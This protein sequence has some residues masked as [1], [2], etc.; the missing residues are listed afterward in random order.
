VS[1]SVA[2]LEL[3][4]EEASA[5]VALRNLIPRILG[6]QVAFHIHAYQGKPDLLNKLPNR[7]KGYRGW[8]PDDWRIVVLIDEDREDCTQIKRKL[9]DIATQAGFMTKS[10]AGVGKPFQVLNRLCVEELEAWFFGDVKAITSA[11]PRVPTSLAQRARFRN[12]DAIVGGTWEALERVL[13]QAGEHRGGL[14]KVRAARE[15]SQHMDPRRNSST[16]FRVFRDGLLQS[17]HK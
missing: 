17:R 5:D 16:S 8:L 7:L 3:L 15:I 4:V 2:H 13:Q 10:D 1:K 14:E 6:S 12:P 11:Y 9:E